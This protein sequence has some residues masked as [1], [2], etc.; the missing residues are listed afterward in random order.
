VIRPA[1][2]LS[3]RILRTNTKD[4]TDRKKYN[5]LHTEPIEHIR[6]TTPRLEA[7]SL[8][9]HTLKV[10]ETSFFPPE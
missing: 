10:R 6:N 4:K 1:K 8:R 2:S 9:Q 3:A 5:T 7:K